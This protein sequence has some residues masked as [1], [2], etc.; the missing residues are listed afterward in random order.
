[1][2]TDEQIKRGSNDLRLAPLVAPEESDLAAAVRVWEIKSELTAG[3]AWAFAKWEQPR[4]EA[5]APMARG[6]AKALAGKPVWWRTR[7]M[8]SDE[9]PVWFEPTGL[10]K[11][12]IYLNGRNVG[13]YWVA[14]AEGKAVPPQ[15]RYYLPAA[16][17]N[18]DGENQLVIFDE[19]GG[20][21]TKSR[22]V[23]ADSAF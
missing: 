9:Q 13:R 7:F 23:Y 8:A 3:A 17:F 11:G 5:F 6:K 21:A 1:V 4:D 22:I 19:H 16:W 15:A 12:Q 20:D 18:P 10:T 14:T 2:L